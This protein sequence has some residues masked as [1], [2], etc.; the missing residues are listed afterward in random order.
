MVQVSGLSLES[1]A[2]W[3]ITDDTQ[4]DVR[5]GFGDTV[6]SP[7]EEVDVL[8][9]DKSSCIEDVKPVF[10]RLGRFDL[11]DVDSVR[12]DFDFVSR[13]TDLCEAVGS[14]ARDSDVGVLAAV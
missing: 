9:L 1:V 6:E 3:A 2:F 10:G 5:H 11:L 8:V 14:D 4:R 7:Q 13:R 12:D